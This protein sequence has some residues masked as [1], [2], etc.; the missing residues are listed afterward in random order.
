MPSARYANALFASP[1]GDAARTQRYRERV[2]AVR[3][4][5]A[6]YSVGSSDKK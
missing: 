1:V 4:F 5:H 6:L 2:F 3:L